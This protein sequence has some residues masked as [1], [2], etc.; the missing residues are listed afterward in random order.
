MSIGAL[1]L[2]G[3]LLFLL[4]QL[5]VGFTFAGE[6]YNCSM[7]VLLTVLLSLAMVLAVV[8]VLRVLVRELA[9]ARSPA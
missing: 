9:P 5:R 6:Q 2:A 7:L 8:L 4:G 3:V 1:G